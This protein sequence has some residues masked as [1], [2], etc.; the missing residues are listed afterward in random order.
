MRLN[1]AARSWMPCGLV[2]DMS[3]GGS[4]HKGAAEAGRL[5][6]KTEAGQAPLIGLHAGSCLM[7]T[8]NMSKAGQVLVDSTSSGCPRRRRPG[9]REGR[10]KKKN[11]PKDLQ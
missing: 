3:L 5:Q 9:R 7:Q 1:C 6:E 11:P 10:K 8:Q 4:R 2:R